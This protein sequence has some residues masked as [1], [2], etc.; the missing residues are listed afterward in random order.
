MGRKTAKIAQKTLI[1]NIDDG[2]LNL[3]YFAYD[4]DALGLYLIKRLCSDRDANW[5]ILSKLFYDYDNLNIYLL[6]NHKIN[7]NINIKDSDHL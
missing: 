1:N 7:N 2:G 3:C 4:I 5:K 6:A